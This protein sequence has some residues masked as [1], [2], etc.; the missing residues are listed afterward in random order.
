MNQEIDTGAPVQDEVE[1]I[2]NVM[3]E[4][5][6]E[7]DLESALTVLCNLAGQLVATMSEGKPSLVQRHGNIIAENVKKAAIAKLLYDDEKTRKS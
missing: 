2:T 6:G 3:M 7:C 1:R 4:A 5:L